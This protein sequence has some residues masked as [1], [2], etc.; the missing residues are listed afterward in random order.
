MVTILQF[1]LRSALLIMTQ[2]MS[3]KKEI[4][5]HRF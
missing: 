3:Q 2:L 1:F 5:L 4:I